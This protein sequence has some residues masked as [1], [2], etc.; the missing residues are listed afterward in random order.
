MSRG[1]DVAVIGGGVIGGSVAYQ[2]AKRGKRV[3]VLEKGKLA[4]GSSLAAAGM[5]GAQAELEKEIGPLFDLAIKSRAMFPALVEELK[6]LSGIDAG[7]INRGMLKVA[8]TEGQAEELQEVMEVQRKAGQQAEWLRGEEARL[9]EPGLGP[10]VLAAMYIPQEGQVLAP[11]LAQSFLKSAAIYGA[12]LR[13]YSQVKG[14][15]MEQGK[16]SGVIL[17][18]ETIECGQVVM[19]AGAWSGWLAEQI[20]LSLP[21]Y[22]VKGECFSVITHRPLL[23]ATVFSHGCYLVPKPGGRLIVGATMK[24][25]T[26]DQKVSVEGIAILMERAK[27]LL[28][29]IIEGEWEKAWAGTRPQTADGLPYI[30]RHPEWKGLFLATGHFRNGIL[31]SPITGE[32]IADLIEKGTTEHDICSFEVG[33]RQFITL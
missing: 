24:E 30:G 26:F 22:P 31:L 19:A 1:Y 18:N 21:V 20:D 29:G 15:Q 8:I 12:E 32:I 4:S 25:H 11:E 7:F 16:V 6:G 3:I 33:R 14:L 2:L 23:Q 9:R 17:E 13:E 27:R 10:E 5:L 28:P